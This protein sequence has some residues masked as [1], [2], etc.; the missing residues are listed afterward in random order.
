MRQYTTQGIC[1]NKWKDR[2]EVLTIS[3]EFDGQTVES[4]NR[5]G[6][7]VIKPQM[8]IQYNKF[9]SGVDFH[10][11]MLAYYPIRR[12]TLR[13]YKKL[14]IHFFQTILLNSYYLYNSKN[15]KMS[16]YDYRLR[17]IEQLLGPPP[18]SIP[19]SMQ[20]HLPNYLPKDDRGKTKRKRCKYCWNE[21]KKRI[22]SIFFC[23]DCEEKPGLCLDPCFRLFHKYT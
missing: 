14:G 15:P 12:K 22:D 7:T 4:V 11:Q 1:V 23:P 19:R 5:R 17:V 20:I 16:L 10:D 6:N 3:S 8:V 2:R 9:M 18:S 13:W 21:S